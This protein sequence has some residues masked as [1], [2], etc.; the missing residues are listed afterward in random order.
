MPSSSADQPCF[1]GFPFFCEDEFHLFAPG[2]A[3]LHALS[4]ID[5]AKCFKYQPQKKEYSE[6]TFSL[7]N[8]VSK[9]GATQDINLLLKK[10]KPKVPTSFQG[11]WNRINRTYNRGVDY[12]D[13]FLYGFSALILAKLANGDAQNALMNLNSG[14]SL[15]L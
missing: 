8:S 15:A 12:L 5:P 13:L 7:E 3:L 1:S 14:Y 6:Y 10:S 2:I 11:S 4:L 9:K